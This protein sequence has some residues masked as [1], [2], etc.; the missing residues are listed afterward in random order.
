MWHETE[1]SDSSAYRAQFLDWA[2]YPE[3]SPRHIKSIEVDPPKP[4]EEVK[5]GDTVSYILSC[6]DVRSYSTLTL[7]S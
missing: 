3:W 6:V 2:K 7:R 5:P 1:T 4:V